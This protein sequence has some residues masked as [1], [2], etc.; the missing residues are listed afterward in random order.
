[1]CT[2]DIAKE[3]MIPEPSALIIERDYKLVAS[4]QGIQQLLAFVLTRDS[5]AQRP[6]EVV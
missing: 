6:A 5:L 2:E 3:V 1:M 4:L